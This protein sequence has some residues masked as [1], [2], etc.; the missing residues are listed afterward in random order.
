VG[1]TERK[2]WNLWKWPGAALTVRSSGL[3]REGRKGPKESSEMMCE[4][5]NAGGWLLV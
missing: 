3:T 2:Y 5:L 1:T 4:K